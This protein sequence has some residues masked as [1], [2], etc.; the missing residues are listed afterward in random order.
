MTAPGVVMDSEG[1]GLVPTKFHCIAVQHEGSVRSTSSYDNMKKFLTT[2]PIIVGHNIIRWDVPNL[3][4]V[5]NIKINARFVDTLALSWY[6]YPNMQ[7][8]GLGEWGELLGVK[9]PEIEDWSSLT[10]EEYRHRC[11]E[12]C[13]INTLLWEKQWAYL[14]KLYGSEDA[15][16]LLIDYLTFKMQCAALQEKCKWKLDIDKCK[17]NLAEL[18]SVYNEKVALLTEGMPEV[19]IVQIKNRPAKPFKKDGSY[20]IIGKQWF[21][22]LLEK[23]LP[24]TYTGT[25]EVRVGYELPNPGS[26]EQIKEWLYSAGWAPQTFKY[27]LDEGASKWGKRLFRTIPQVRKDV[28]GEK[29]LCDSVLA[30]KDKLPAIE[31]LEGVTV[32]NHRIGILKGFL[33]D[34]DEEGYLKAE[35][36]GF[37]NTLRVKHRIVVNLPGVDRPYGKQIRECL[38]AP[39]G[40]EL[41]GSDQSGLEDRLK[42]HYIYPYDP[43]YVKAMN[44]E[45]WD[46]HLDI[47][48]T[49]NMMTAEEVTAYKLG[50]HSKKIVRHRAKTA[51]YSCQYLAG[52]ETISRNTGMPLKDAQTLHKAYWERNWAIKAAAEA[53]EVKII[54]GQSW[55]LNPISKFWYSLRA[56]KD[57]FST[58]VQGLASYCFDTWVKYILE[59][60]RNLVASFHDEVVLCL[61]I[62]NRDKCISV[63]QKAIDLT[64]AELKLNRK[65]DISIDFGKS[66]SE[67]H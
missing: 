42:Q 8:H 4:R 44:T 18:E 3:E 51:N 57:K 32:L 21:D 24:E 53:F 1:D 29:V 10:L 13:K 37:T 36:G 22:L 38:T 17:S 54:D 7:K 55:L 50:D 25:V 28:N 23:G 35:I 43:E 67:I 2:T 48:L 34:V 66:Y 31:H 58:G 14:L 62:G 49:A 41:C 65:L 46:P 15:A 60:R 12:D 52:P 16:W 20:S 6:L 64:N 61:K 59:Q 11:S 26:N 19:P 63:L 56:E 33:R 9:K 45:D 39:D 5:L 27:V 47:A 30:L 40:Y